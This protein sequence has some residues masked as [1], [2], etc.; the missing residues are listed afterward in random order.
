M[1]GVSGNEKQS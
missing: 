1:G